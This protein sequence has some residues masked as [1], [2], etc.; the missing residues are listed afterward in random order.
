MRMVYLFL[1]IKSRHLYF[2]SK[3]LSSSYETISISIYRYCFDNGSLVYKTWNADK[4]TCIAE[5][6]LKFHNKLENEKLYPMNDTN[7]MNAT[8]A[9]LLMRSE[10]CNRN[11]IFIK[12][13]YRFD[14]NIS[15]AE[16]YEDRKR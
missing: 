4:A 1:G 5:Q 11:K 15:R 7:C 10:Y 2:L 12:M 8:L 13:Q 9:D 3:Y 6:Q 14:Q 16:K